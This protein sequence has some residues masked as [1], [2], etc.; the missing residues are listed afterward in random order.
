MQS[1]AGNCWAETDERNGVLKKDARSR[2]VAFTFHILFLFSL[3]CLNLS[4]RLTQVM[5]CLLY[6]LE[7]RHSLFPLQRWLFSAPTLAISGW[8]QSA[9][10]NIL[11]CCT[12]QLALRVGWKCGFKGREGCLFGLPFLCVCLCVVSAEKVLFWS[13]LFF[14]SYLPQFVLYLC[15][16]VDYVMFFCVTCIHCL[17]DGLARAISQGNM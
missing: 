7:I 13:Q 2:A 14:Q 4:L 17:A 6:R 9:R 1:P 16:C 15:V 10:V 5:Y 12:H 8:V 11:P 3:F